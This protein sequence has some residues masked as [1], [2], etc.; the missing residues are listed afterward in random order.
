MH[1]DVIVVGAGS[2]GMAAGY[3]L[4]K[5]GK[6]TL[7]L[8]AFN[9][10]HDQ[11]S[12][13]G[14]TRIIRYAYGEGAE[15]VPFALRAR[16]LWQD[17]AQQTGKEIFLQTGVMNVG[18]ENIPFIKNV[19]ASAEKF[20]LPLEVMT[21]TE[22]NEKWPGMQLPANFVGCFEPTSGVL[23]VEA[24]VEGYRELASSAGA[25]IRTNSRVTKVDV[26]PQKVTIET[27]DGATF[28]ANAAII[29][30]GAW[31]GELLTQ[32]DLELPLNPIRK[33]FAW[34]DV[35]EKYYNQHD[36]PAFA[37]ELEESIYYGF[38]SID[39]AGLKVGRHDGGDTVNPDE[40][41]L[42]FGEIAGD[43]EDLTGFLDE[44]M[45][46]EHE[47]K[48]GKTCMYTMTPDEDFIIDVHPN[49]KNIAIA[50]GFSGHGFKFA[51]AVGEVLCD[52]ITKGSTDLDIAPFSM[53]RFKSVGNR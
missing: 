38:P 9:P 11:G 41:N 27:V 48:F 40:S 17:L 13:H 44:F 29:S 2:M 1:Y 6:K 50:A 36:F 10:P 7:L 49:H 52:L 8:D 45:P 19:I 31:A 18:D 39:G 25:I 30:A 46:R 26:Q 43:A 28:T 51:S 4:A 23:R 22:V 12:H 33:T 21:A 24:C 34:Y 42:P 37:F 20:D 14:E 53:K 35:D 15:Y 16:D 5:S 47:L 3:F 32:L